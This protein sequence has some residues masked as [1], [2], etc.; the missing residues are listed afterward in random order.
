MCGLA[1]NLL[2]ASL[3]HIAGLNRL[4]ELHFSLLAVNLSTATVRALA[5][6]QNLTVLVMLT[7]G[8]LL[9]LAACRQ[10]QKLDCNVPVAELDQWS[11]GDSQRYQLLSK[12]G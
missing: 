2:Q 10:L 7:I 3:G 1:V 11:L 6:I 4:T 9:Q 12:V 5:D 8:A